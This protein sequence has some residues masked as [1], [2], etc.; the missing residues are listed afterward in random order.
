ME[1]NQ[2]SH[3]ALTRVAS[4]A[5][6]HD[7]PHSF[8]T[9][10][11]GGN[12]DAAQEA[13]RRIDAWKQGFRLDKKLTVKFDRKEPEAA[14]GDAPAA[15]QKAPKPSAK[16]KA[17]TAAKS[18]SGGATAAKAESES[19]APAQIRLIVRLDFSDHEKLSL[20]RWIDRIPTEEPFKAADPQVIRAGEAEFKTISDLY[21]SLD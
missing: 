20:Q 6:M 18:K 17:K 1:L 11:F 15:P 12:E 9:F 19:S 10:D 16:G 5:N 13:R 21:D 8:L 14:L 7:M 4:P 2:L 3:P